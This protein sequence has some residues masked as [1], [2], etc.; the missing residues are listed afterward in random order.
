MAKPWLIAIVDDEPSVRKALRRLLSASGHQVRTFASGQEFLEGRANG[1]HD[2]LVLDLH[3]P[4]FSGLEVQRELARV[5]ELLPIVIITAFDEPE[6]RAQCL[7]AG[8][9]AYLLKP[10][11]DQT[12]LD[13]IANAIESSSSPDRD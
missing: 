12:L 4:G 8:A 10:F 5:G 11:D 3:M 1:R 9:T 2:C 6:S 7:S 13:A